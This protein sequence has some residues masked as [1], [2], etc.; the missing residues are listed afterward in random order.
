MFFNNAINLHSKQ[1]ALNK[2]N[3]SSRE[4]P[5]HDSPLVS[6]IIPVYNG[7]ETIC[8]A[9][10]SAL[11]QTYREREVIV[12][13]HG[14]TDSNTE[15]LRKYGSK[16]RAVEL[17]NAGAT[18]PRNYGIQLARGEYVAF[19]DQDDF[20]FEEKLATQVEIL[21]KHP[22]IGLTFSNLECIDRQG[23]RLG[24]TILASD[25]RYSPSWEDLLLKGVPPPSALLARR[26]IIVN[27][28][29]FDPDLCISQ[30]YEDRDLCL[31]LRELTDF[32]YLD[33]CLGYYCYHLEGA[34]RHLRNLP[35]FAR[36]Y[37]NHPRVQ[38][39]S[40]RRFRDQFVEKCA[41]WMI[42]RMRIL[43]ES[44]GG[45]VSKEMVITLNG[46][47]DILKGIFGESYKRVSHFDTVDLGKYRLDPAISS[48]LYL[49]LCRP[50]LQVAF[51]EVRAGDISRLAG[52][53][54]GDV[55]T[56]GDRLILLEH[57]G[58]LERLA[59]GARDQG[60]SSRIARKIRFGKEIRKVLIRGE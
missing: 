29:G 22:S 43:L 30:G 59:G 44:E 17:K 35:L 26:E 1:M 11:D 4:I 20:W 51:P 49:Y 9:I 19:L 57:F 15:L 28:G 53:G 55:H 24:F 58:D 21:E 2:D 47:H 60:L 8:R 48:L 40:D 54:V 7:Q 39:D 37:W 38:Q 6:V 3:N 32:H 45:R 52:W 23:E 18:N 41:R 13:D 36:K 25:L 50:D 14:P 31:R 27:V 5:R 34:V 46:L 42:W 56:D 16:I 12:V 33:V 10:D